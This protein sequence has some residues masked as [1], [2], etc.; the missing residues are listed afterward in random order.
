MTKHGWFDG[1]K[2]VFVFRDIL[3]EAGKFLR[4]SCLPP[5]E[6]ARS[7]VV[8]MQGSVDHCV[9]GVQIL[10][11]LVT[12]MNQAESMRSLTKHRKVAGSFRDESLYDIFT[13]SC[14][15][16]QQIN[17]RDESQVSQVASLHECGPASLQ[18]LLAASSLPRPGLA[19]SS[20]PWSGLAWLPLASP[21][22]GLAASSLYWLPPAFLGLAWLPPASTGG[23]PGLVGDDVTAIM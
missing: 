21:R 17:V 23:W 2:K 19:V 6:H 11:Q 3:D 22:P 13:L 18:P 15:L 5:L 12:E 14:T 10:H 16:L 4:V 20:L 8:C 1:D 7:V 9:I